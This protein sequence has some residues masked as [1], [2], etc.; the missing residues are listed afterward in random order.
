MFCILFCMTATQGHSCVKIHWV[1]QF[2]FGQFTP[3]T[4]CILYCDSKET[5]INLDSAPYPN[6]ELPARVLPVLRESQF[7][8]LP[9]SPP[10]SLPCSDHLCLCKVGEESEPSH[11]G[12]PPYSQTSRQSWKNSTLKSPLHFHSALLLKATLRAMSSKTLRTRRSSTSFAT[13]HP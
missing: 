1:V 5:K 8:H 2:R 11:L 10:C 4:M 6:Q 3:F 13:R 9:R 12:G 7:H